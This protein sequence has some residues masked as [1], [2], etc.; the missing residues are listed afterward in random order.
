M[1]LL[2]TASNELPAPDSGLEALYDRM[3]VR[4]W[5]DRVQEKSNFQAMLASDGQ[6]HQNPDPLGADSGKSTT[7]GRMPSS[8]CACRT[9]VS[10]SSTSC[11]SSSTV[12]SGHGCYVSDRRWKKAVRL[13]KAS[14]FFNGRDEVAPLDLLLFRIASGTTRLPAPR[15]WR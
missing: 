7:P 12:Y 8:R 6:S 1:R 14:A 5:M 10:N 2:V 11:A 4:V 3:L 15:C 9:P 13:I